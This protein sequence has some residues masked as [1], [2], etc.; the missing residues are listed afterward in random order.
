MPVA[1]AMNSKS[2]FRVFIGVERR[3][4]TTFQFSDL[5]D[6][7]DIMRL[8]SVAPRAKRHSSQSLG[9]F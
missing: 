7:P 8:L 5:L 2:C 1:A 3:C 6:F 9:L 4:M